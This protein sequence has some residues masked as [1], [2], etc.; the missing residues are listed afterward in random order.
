LVVE[1]ALV[2]ESEEEAVSAVVSGVEEVSAAKREV[3]T[4][5]AA[6]LHHAG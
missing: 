1:S 6:S 5:E 4:E 2:V 3:S